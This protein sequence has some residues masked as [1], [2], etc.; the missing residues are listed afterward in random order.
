[1]IAVAR[2]KQYRLT[3]YN[4]TVTALVAKTAVGIGSVWSDATSA[5]ELIM[6]ILLSTRKNFEVL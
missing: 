4:R 6:V 5:K 2:L 3:A 1:M